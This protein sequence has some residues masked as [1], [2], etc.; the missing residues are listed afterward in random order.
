[1]ENDEIN[2]EANASKQTKS[3]PVEQTVQSENPRQ[4]RNFNKLFLLAVILI[5][6]AGGYWFWK[7][8]QL[9]KEAASRRVEIP[10]VVVK[11]MTTERTDV[12]VTLEYTGQTNG[13]KQAEVRAQV[14]G[15]LIRKEYAEGQPV[16]S[17]QIL[18]RIDPA[19]YR[20]ALNKNI[21]AMKQS[22]VQLNLAKIDY[23]RVSA[24]YKKNAVS[25]ADFDNA[26]ASLNASKAALDAAKAAVRQSQI[27]LNWTVV[28][29]PISGLS[30]K[31][32]CSVGNL[33]TTDSNGSLLTT[34][35][36]ADPVYVDFAVP[37]DEQ[38]V[39]EK[40]K[41]SGIVKTAPEGIMVSVALGDGT[42]YNKKGK[43]DFQD[44][45]VD[46][47]T[48]TIR[49]RAKFE[50]PGNL[51]YPG[52]FVRVYVTGNIVRNVIEIPLRA[53]IQ[54]AKGSIVYVLDK[55]NIPAMR[56]VR[57]VY[58]AGNSCMVAGGVDAG[59][60]IVVDGVGKV[61]PGKAVTIQKDE[62]ASSAD[63]V[64]GDTAGGTTDKN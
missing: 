34:I 5:I 61:L 31:E 9:K 2:N 49:A 35:V 27:D 30:S 16:K 44:K 22:E 41:S 20:A 51:L 26:D 53:I 50:N 58:K 25:K 18:F 21:G 8:E 14:S 15:I 11:E 38:R 4:G 28:R 45:F 33:I 23:D 6:A 1:M 13:Y 59:E 17:G 39:L 57:I 52:Q 24:L 7:T 54:T 60:R 36:Q 48:A 47:D 62:P 19:P 29:A 63:S 3:E 64:P 32:N 12:P 37:A 42:L 56:T 43:I 46:P 55:N 40:L 10:P